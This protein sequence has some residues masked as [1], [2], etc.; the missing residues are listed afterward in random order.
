D[1]LTGAPDLRMIAPEVLERIVL[2]SGGFGGPR[3]GAQEVHLVTRRADPAQSQSRMGIY[4]GSYQINKVGGGL[5]RR[6]FG[7]AALHVDINKIEQRTEDLTLKVEQVQYFTRLE[8]NLRGAAVISLEGLF[9]S[10]DRNPRG[11]VGKLKQKNTHLHAAI[12]GRLGERAGYRLGYRYAVSTHP[13]LQ[14]GRAVHLKARADG[15]QAQFV[16]R[17]GRGLAVGIDLQ[18]ER[19]RPLDFQDILPEDLSLSIHSQLGFLRLQAPGGLRLHATGGL[20]QVPGSAGTKAVLDL[21]A[22]R[23]FSGRVSAFLAWKRDVSYPDLAALYSLSCSGAG[24]EDCRPARLDMLDGGLEFKPAGLGVLR[25]GLT[26]R[27]LSG[28]AVSGFSPDPLTA[29]EYTPLDYT[30]NGFYYRYEGRVWSVFEL[31]A[32]GVELFDPPA[33]VS[34]LARRRHTAVLGFETSLLHG[35]MGFGLQAEV[36]Y[37]GE[38]FFPLGSA[39]AAGL[40]RQ[41]GRVNFGGS[42]LLRIIDLTIYC[43]LDH[44]MSDYYNGIDPFRLPG[45]RAIFGLNWEFRN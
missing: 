34:Y 27:R 22:S 6:L 10:N 43:R 35:D 14:D 25:A 2:T 5:R 39:Q 9:F 19:N 11:T 26:H 40:A 45:P 17:P 31:T 24:M 37:E 41:P 12:T 33:G 18:G 32:E 13:F 23:S 21:G 1:P 28:Q 38:F 7:S 30:V 16:L 3:G 42:G 4:G 44:L 20:R 29:G 36:V 15:Y 8:K